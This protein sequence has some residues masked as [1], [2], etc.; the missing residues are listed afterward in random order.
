MR[1]Q[2]MSAIVTALEG[3]GLVERRPHLTD[4]RQV[5]IALTPTGARA[6]HEARAAKSTWLAQAIATLDPA[7]RKALPSLTALVKRLADV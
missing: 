7:E 4:G 3:R 1:P 5:H 2:S 6:R